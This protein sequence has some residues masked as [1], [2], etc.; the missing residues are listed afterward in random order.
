MM[1]D[2]EPLD[3]EDDS[4]FYNKKRTGLTEILKASL[5]DQFSGFNGSATM[6]ENSSKEQ[7]FTELKRNSTMQKKR[8]IN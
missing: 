6:K 5:T 8:D 7:Q 4:S 2:E 1:V 3:M